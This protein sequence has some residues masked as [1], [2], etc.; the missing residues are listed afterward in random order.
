MSSS[1]NISDKKIYDVFLSFRGEDTRA[2][3]T[4]HL[5]ASLQNAGIH[6][7]RDDNSLPRGENIYTILRSIE[8][9]RIAIIIF[10][11]NYAYSWWCLQELEKIMECN[12]TN[13]QIVLPL[14]YDVNPSEVRH[15]SGEFGKAFQKLLSTIKKDHEFPFELNVDRF[16]YHDHQHHDDHPE[17]KWRGALRQAAAL[18]G[19]VVLNSR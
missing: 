3:F 2:S 16:S 4:S 10:S 1:S 12:R 13:G 11:T 14:F 18:A 7:F 15:Q 9:S 8:E 6:V 19:F 17:I 5:Y